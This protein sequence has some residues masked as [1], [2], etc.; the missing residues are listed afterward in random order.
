MSFTALIL[1]PIHEGAAAAERELAAF[2]PIRTYRT[3][4]DS[5]GPAQVAQALSD[6]AESLVVAGGDGNV[7]DPQFREVVRDVAPTTGG[8]D[9]DVVPAA[10]ISP[11][12]AVRRGGHKLLW[13]G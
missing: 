8:I 13:Q 11:S 3:T 1:N 9:G 7:H 2:G 5:P 4:P 6:G 10:S 12:V